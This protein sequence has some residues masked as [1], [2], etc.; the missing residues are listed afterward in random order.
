ME[1]D[2]PKPDLYPTFLPR[3]LTLTDVR[4][5][6]P[7]KYV[8]KYKKLAVIIAVSYIGIIYSSVTTFLQ[9]KIA[10]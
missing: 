1:L 7:Q 6:H 10:K 9:W 8:W 2:L 3:E 4:C 5:I